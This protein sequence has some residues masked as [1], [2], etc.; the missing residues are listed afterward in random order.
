MYIYAYLSISIFL[1]FYKYICIYQLLPYPYKFQS[2]IIFL[3]EA[4]FSSAAFIKRYV[5]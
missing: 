4:E 1:S 5:N 3:S 2:N